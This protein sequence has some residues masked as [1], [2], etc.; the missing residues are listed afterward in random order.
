[1]S[2]QQRPNTNQVEKNVYVLTLRM[3]GE[4]DGAMQELRSRWFPKERNK[5]PAHITLFHALPGSKMEE[6]SDWLEGLSRRMRCFDVSTG[7]VLK[8][9][10]GVAVAV[11]DGAKE[12]KRVFA[13]LRADWLEWLSVQDRSLS[14][15]WTVQNKELDKE[16]VEEA[17]RNVLQCEEVRGQATGLVLWRYKDDGTWSLEKE[18]GFA[19]NGMIKEDSGAVQEIE[20]DNG[21]RS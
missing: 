7:R 6:I 17:F 21:K 11:G 14:A 5:V 15:H 10:T 8:R 19:D 3:S 2:Q 12:I 1:M 4:I 9:K 18:F 13:C 20:D 16:R